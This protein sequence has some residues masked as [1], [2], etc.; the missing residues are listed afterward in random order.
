MFVVVRQPYRIGDRIAV[1][2]PYVE[3][4]SDGSPTWIVKSVSLLN[5]VCV[6]GGTSEL[7]TYSNGAL[8]QQ[9]II[10]AARSL[11]AIL[12]FVLSF[13]L[14]P[15]P[16]KL[17][18]FKESIE[19]FIKARPREWVSLTVFR[20]AGVEVTEGML[21]CSSGG[22]LMGSHDGKKPV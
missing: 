12:T 11:H 16:E 14:N 7:C 3:T 6:L 2:Q 20:L 9:R 5:T 8:A 21:Q 18:I 22:D 13:P 15:P 10:N 17:T 4:S 19:K 1:S